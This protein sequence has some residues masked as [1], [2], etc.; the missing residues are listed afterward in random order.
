M[1]MVTDSPHAGLVFIISSK[2]LPTTALGMAGHAA[3][4]SCD[5]HGQ[6]R[7]DMDGGASAGVHFLNV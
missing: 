7:A 1:V 6:V 2:I 3:I 4:S 5:Q